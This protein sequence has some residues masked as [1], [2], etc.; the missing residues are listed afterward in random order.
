[1]SNLL[2]SRLFADFLTLANQYLQLK[3][4]IAK[5]ELEKLQ[6]EELCA[7]EVCQHIDKL[8]EEMRWVEGTP[9]TYRTKVIKDLRYLKRYFGE[10]DNDII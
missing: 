8:I 10:E 5:F 6:Q 2:N 7:K 9:R 1:M 4:K 3:I